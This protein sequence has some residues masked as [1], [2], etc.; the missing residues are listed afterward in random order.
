MESAKDTA[1]LKKRIENERVYDFLAGLDSGFDQI[2]VQVLAQDPLPNLRSTYAF[3]RREELRQAAMLTSPPQESS[4]LMTIHHSPS[5]LVSSGSWKPE[6]NESLFCTHC[7]GTKHT[8]ETCFKLNGYPNWFRKKGEGSSRHKGGKTD[9]RAH[10]TTFHTPQPQ[11]SQ[12]QVDHILKENAQRLSQKDASCSLANTS[13]LGYALNTPNR[14]CCES[15]WIIDSGS[16]DHM[17]H[18][19]SNFSSYNT[20]PSKRCVKTANG[21]SSAMSGVSSLPLTSSMSLST[22]LHVPHLSGK[23]LSISQI[24]KELKCF[25]TFF[26][27]HCVFQDLLTRATI[28]LGRERDG[29]YYLDLNWHAKDDTGQVHQ[30]VGS[31]TSQAQIWLWHRRLGHPS[32]HYL[33]KLFPSLFSKVNVSSFHCDSCL[34][35]KHHHTSF[36]SSFNKSSV[37]F[38]IIHSD[39]WGPFR[40]TN[41]SNTKWFV[42]F[43]D[44]CTHVSW[45]YLLKEKSE[46]ISIFQSFH[47]MI[48]TQFNTRV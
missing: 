37:P 10:T 39:V 26:D 5:V 46:V 22:V 35:A 17:T 23:L 13:N 16:T 8:R 14:D 42:S 4:A 1:T 45:V 19:S 36:H 33:L 25:V 40:V 44:D 28:G 2:R 24:T 29:L 32:F 31:S 41:R 11:Y 27:T 7:K 18:E 43:I 48:L 15:S 9:S 38:S 20:Y 21:S 34:L 47:Q 12:A 3:V 6:D 30:V